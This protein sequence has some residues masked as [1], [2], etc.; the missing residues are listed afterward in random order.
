MLKVEDIQGIGEYCRVLGH[1]AREASRVFHRSRNTVAKVLKQGVEGFR[2]REVRRRKPRVLLP[3]H[4][5]YID[6]MLEGRKGGLQVG[7]QKHNALTV[8]NHLRSELDYIGSV[9]QVRRYIRRRRSELG[10]CRG[11]VSLDR[12]REPQGL[13]EAD[14]TEVK[15]YLGSALI[16]VWLFVMR[17]RFSG[18]LFVRA[19][20]AMGTESLLDGL[21]CGFEHFG[22]VP[23][24]QLDNQKAAVIKL[25]KGRARL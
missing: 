20:R 24:V 1:S 16:S 17:F 22:G 21:Q 10:I 23:T 15:V 6:D 7:K 2:H 18:A 19:Y 9:S 14:W 13:C 12:V 11:E 4:Q 25:L 5:R 3:V 8:A